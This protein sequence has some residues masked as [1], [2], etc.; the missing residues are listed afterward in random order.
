MRKLNQALVFVHILI[1]SHVC[2]GGESAFLKMQTCS[3]L[4]EVVTSNK[5]DYIVDG[6]ELGILCYNNNKIS[7]Q[8]LTKLVRNRML[9]M[10]NLEE[11]ALKDLSIQ[12][13]SYILE[14]SSQREKLIGV[15]LLEHAVTLD[16]NSK[17]RYEFLLATYYLNQCCG[18]NKTKILA[19]L[20]ESAEEN[21]ILS[22]AVLMYLFQG[23]YC[24]KEDSSQFSNFDEKFKYLANGEVT[25]ES[26]IE[27]LQ[28]K[29][30]IIRKR[31]E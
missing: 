4:A 26:V 11:L 14:D 8:Q 3:K 22:M 19:L 17:G 25:F 6:L 30:V 7:D 20:A 21:N 27:Y 16:I 9:G 12:I 1:V 23:N 2:F 24:I 15:Q 5:D 13:G 29:G 31:I 28:S 10:S 18:L